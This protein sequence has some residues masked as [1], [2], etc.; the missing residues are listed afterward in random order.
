[1]WYLVTLLWAAMQLTSCVIA[2]V[3]F[4][5]WGIGVARCIPVLKGLI[6]LEELVPLGICATLVFLQLV[7]NYIAITSMVLA[8]WL[9]VGFGAV[10]IHWQSLCLSVSHVRSTRWWLWVPAA[11]LILRNS[12]DAVCYV[13]QIDSY[14]FLSLN[15]FHSYAT[16][17]GVAN[18]EGRF[19]FNCVSFLIHAMFTVDPIAE[20]GCGILHGCLVI[21]ILAAAVPAVVRTA[22]SRS[23][24]ID[25]VSAVGLILPVSFLIGTWRT[26]FSTAGISPDCTVFLLQQLIVVTWLRAAYGHLT[27]AKDRRT[28][29]L[30][31]LVVCLAV[32]LVTVKLSAAVFAS[33]L[34]FS[35]F[36]MMWLNRRLCIQLSVRLSAI[37]FSVAAGILLPWIF[38]G[39]MQSG[40]PAYPSAIAATGVE[41]QVSEQMRRYELKLIG[42]W[43]RYG[44][45]SKAY[46]EPWIEQWI[47]T[48]VLG[49]FG[50]S[51][52]PKNL[53]G[54]IVFPGVWIAVVL[55]RLR[56]VP[57]GSNGRFFKLVQVLF[58]VGFLSGI[59]WVL[60]APDPRF[61]LGV[62]YSILGA[63]TSVLCF[64]ET[65]HRRYRLL[66]ISIL[67]IVVCSFYDRGM[68]EYLRGYNTQ[69]VIRNMFAFFPPNSSGHY[70]FV[71]EIAEE[72]VTSSGL[73]IYSANVG[74]RAPRLSVQTFY[75]GWD[76]LQLRNPDDFSSGFRLQYVP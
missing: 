28:Q 12:V 3:A 11:V 60:T 70:K 50:A 17:P 67:I 27:G 74:F 10:F 1:M 62:C 7:H 31:I 26:N 72:R 46:D 30:S 21:T 71:P 51:G 20:L 43:A 73:K 38:R 41:W 9:T 63:T 75:P 40:Y 37:G 57:V 4:F 5:G 34:L 61:F 56:Q 13:P 36:L 32:M 23:V 45:M 44:R 35:L 15:W 33:L 29:A 42:D 64:C 24:S 39:V 48:N 18:L 47:W 65:Q 66:C 14:H 76:R 53:T 6:R 58:L 19:G 49:P 25:T 2:L 54:G 52:R 68:N 59:Y 22:T 8:V 69:I 16:V 55:F